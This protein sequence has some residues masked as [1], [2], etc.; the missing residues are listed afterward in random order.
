MTVKRSDEVTAPISREV[1]DSHQSQF[2]H[3]AISPKI[4]IENGVES[5]VESY[6]GG[7]IRT[8]G[9][10]EVG[11]SE[12]FRG[13]PRQSNRQQCQQKRNDPPFIRFFFVAVGTSPA[14][15]CFPARRSSGC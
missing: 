5:A 2:P 10:R 14:L 8:P 6:A 7:S 11:G 13:H 1:R 15:P 4:F 3:K 9:D 12:R